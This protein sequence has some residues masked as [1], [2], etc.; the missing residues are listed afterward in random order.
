MCATPQRPHSQP[1]AGWRSC[2]LPC[3]CKIISLSCINRHILVK[4]GVI[5][6]AEGRA[7]SEN[8]SRKYFLKHKIPIFNMKP[9][10]HTTHP[11]ATQPR[12]D[13]PHRKQSLPRAPE[14]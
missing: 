10:G 1:S 9:Q 6:R 3:L 7:R 12:L 5:H 11:N 8:S 13:V 4:A 14:A 2:I